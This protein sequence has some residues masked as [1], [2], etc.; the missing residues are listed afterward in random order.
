MSQLAPEREHYI[1]F[2]E[3]NSEEVLQ[4]L[5]EVVK[6]CKQSQNVVTN[7]TRA[8]LSVPLED[9]INSPFLHVDFCILLF[10]Y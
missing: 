4:H 8:N 5:S 2:G 10:V 6:Q 3:S 1:V 7:Q 9:N